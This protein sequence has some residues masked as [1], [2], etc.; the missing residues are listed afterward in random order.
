MRRG[1]WSAAV[2]GAA[3]LMAVIPTS[4]FAQSPQP[5]PPIFK[6][7]MV[8]TICADVNYDGAINIGDAKF[9]IDGVFKCGPTPQP[10][11]IGDLNGDGV[12]NI[13][14]AIYL[15]NHIFRGGPPPEPCCVDAVDRTTIQR[16]VKC[17]G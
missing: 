5:S 2:I 9:L 12:Y 17:G 16:L 4:I 7:V 13:A 8:D 6:A 14:D 10:Y 15:I 11:C 1:A 3:S